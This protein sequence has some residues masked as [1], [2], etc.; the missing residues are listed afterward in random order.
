MRRFVEPGVPLVLGAARPAPQRHVAHP[1]GP[2]ARLREPTRRHMASMRFS[3]AYREQANARTDTVPAYGRIAAQASGNNDLSC[4][5][6]S[7]DQAGSRVMISARKLPSVTVRLRQPQPG[8]APGHP[9]TRIGDCRGVTEGACHETSLPSPRSGPMS[10]AGDDD[11]DLL[12]QAQT[13]MS[14]IMSKRRAESSLEIAT[15][16]ASCKAP[17]AGTAP[18]A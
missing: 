3:A 15:V 17:E 7:A 13:A 12:H 5:F 11:E 18:S 10:G 2:A 14:P 9:G 1:P 8:S 4:K 6:K 16:R